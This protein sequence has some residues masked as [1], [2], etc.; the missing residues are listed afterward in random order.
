MVKKLRLTESDFDDTPMWIIDSD[1]D[2]KEFDS[3]LIQNK[4]YK[5]LKQLASRYDYKCPRWVYW[6]KGRLNFVLRPQKDA[7]NHNYLPDIHVENEKGLLHY[8]IELNSPSFA[9]KEELSDLVT[10]YN[11][12]IEMLKFIEN[13]DLDNL[14]H[15]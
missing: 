7:P 1:E 8:D 9:S 4:V 13:L 10:G 14:E 3:R 15:I 5:E 11:N 12:V 6:D 2:T